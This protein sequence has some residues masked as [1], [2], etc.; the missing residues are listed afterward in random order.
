[1]KNMNNS[2]YSVIFKNYKIMNLTDVANYERATIGKTYKAGSTIVQVSATQGQSIY[3]HKDQEVES[4]YVVI[5]A[6]VEILPYYLYVVIQKAMPDFC[7]KYQT[8]LNIQAEAFEMMK[9][10]VHGKEAQE[11]IAKYY[12]LIEEAEEKEV[13]AIN[14]L[15]DVKANLLSKMF[16]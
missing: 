13:Q 2:S 11:I 6:K 16:V 12:R 8:G 3:L 4:K 5:S 7:N 14:A 15:M 10:E 1:M 9:I